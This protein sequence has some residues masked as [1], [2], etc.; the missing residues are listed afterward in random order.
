MRLENA[1]EDDA[2]A[3]VF[4]FFWQRKWTVPRLSR[5]G[6]PAWETRLN[7]WLLS[8]NRAILHTAGKSGLKTTHKAFNT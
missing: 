6:Q 1:E 8:G 4:L 7:K 2:G 5:E 3:R